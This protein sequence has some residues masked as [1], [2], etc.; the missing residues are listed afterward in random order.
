MWLAWVTVY[1]WKTGVHR[2]SHPESTGD[3]PIDSRPQTANKSSSE[4]TPPISPK[5]IVFVCIL[6]CWCDWHFLH[7]LVQPTSECCLPA[8]CRLLNDL[9]LKIPSGSIRN[10]SIYL[11]KLIAPEFCT[12]IRWM[13][14]REK[15]LQ[16]LFAVCLILYSAVPI[17]Y[18][19]SISK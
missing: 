2:S 12:M 6:C 19:T 1:D 11:P 3:P 13:E 8:S 15:T 10:L 16:T 7:F 5:K 9:S 17:W 18:F 14:Q 4:S